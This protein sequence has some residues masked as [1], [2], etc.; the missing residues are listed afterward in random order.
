MELLPLEPLP[1]P[2]SPPPSLLPPPPPPLASGRPDRSAHPSTTSSPYLTGSLFGAQC[3]SWL[4][5]NIGAAAAEVTQ[6]G[7]QLPSGLRAAPRTEPAAARPRTLHSEGC[8][9]F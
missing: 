6:R 1:P 9:K 5:E 2:R 7:M 8:T 3:S 4:G